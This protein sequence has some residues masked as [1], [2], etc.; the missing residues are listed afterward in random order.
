MARCHIIGAG[1]F[2]PEKFEPQPE[3]FIIAADGGYAHLE[4]AGLRP[5]LLLGDFDSLEN[6]PANVEIISFPREKDATDTMLASEE[7][8]RR[9]YDEL[10][11]YGATGSRLDHSLA[12]IQLLADLSQKKARAILVGPNFSITAVT[13]SSLHF[14]AKARGTISVFCNGADAGGVSLRG[15]KYPLDNVIL[16]A[17]CP[18][19]VSNEFT[20]T[21][22]E[23]EVKTGTLIV[24]WY[25]PAEWLE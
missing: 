5:D 24:I 4:S 10:L 25:G 23:A 11:I 15:L 8:M 17:N 14:N 9:G 3:D 1:D 16:K 6:R 12:N 7:A 19:G 21:Q 18:L 2:C 22:A 20:G 13:D